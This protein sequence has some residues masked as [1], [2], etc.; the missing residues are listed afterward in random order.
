MET[1]VSF[2]QAKERLAVR[3][4]EKR[5]ERGRIIGTGFFQLKDRFLF[6][7]GT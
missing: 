6:S 1:R 3:S 7:I 4:N 2:R 5:M